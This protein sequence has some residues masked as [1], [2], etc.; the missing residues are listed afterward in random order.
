ML[1]QPWNRLPV[2]T[3]QGPQ[4]NLALSSRWAAPTTSHHHHSMAY[5]NSR[6]AQE[7]LHTLPKAHLG[8]CSC[9]VWMCSS[10]RD[11]G[12][13][14]GGIRETLLKMHYS[15]VLLAA[16]ATRNLPGSSTAFCSDIHRIHLQCLAK[17]MLLC[18]WPLHFSP[19][20]KGQRKLIIKRRQTQISA[21]Y[22]I[23]LKPG[24]QQL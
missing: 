21:A 11:P 3:C 10:H 19:L 1:A 20:S 18:S 15:C 2:V 23:C 4:L 9:P 7:A 13:L 24:K 12:C 5:H 22:Q 8:P 6:T 17:H 14:T 16:S